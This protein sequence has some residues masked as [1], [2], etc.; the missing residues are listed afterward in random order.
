MLLHNPE[1]SKSRAALNL[2]EER[3]RLDGLQIQLTV[4][5]YLE[6]PLSVEELADLY[7]FLESPPHTE[8]LREPK[9]NV[10]R[11]LLNKRV[12][13]QMGPPEIDSK[14]RQSD[15]HINQSVFAFVTRQPAML[16]RPIAVLGSRA[17]IGRPPE[18]VLELF[19]TET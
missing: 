2:L 15:E 16:Q 9:S 13:V 18:R 14:V 17:V 4:R 11:A 12:Y 6:D 10:A 5:N 1:C 7:S 8:W 19:S 3:A